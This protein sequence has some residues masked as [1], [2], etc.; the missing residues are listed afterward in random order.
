MSNSAWTA[1][2]FVQLW[3]QGVVPLRAMHFLDDA[4]ERQVLRE[5]GPTYQ[6]LHTRLRDRL[7]ALAADQAI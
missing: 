4:C 1:V 3:A 7:T 6:V 5:T 2:V